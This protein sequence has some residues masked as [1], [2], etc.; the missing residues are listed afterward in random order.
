MKDLVEELL[1]LIEEDAGVLRCVEETQRARQ[2]VTGGTS[3]QRQRQ[4]Y[5]KACDSGAAHHDALCAVVRGLIDEFT[6]D[7]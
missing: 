3:S 2:I 5:A 1:V 4:V 6:A 7:L